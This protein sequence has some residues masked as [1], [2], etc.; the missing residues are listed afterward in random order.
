LIFFLVDGEVIC[1]YFV[2]EEE[3][4]QITVDMDYQEEEM[5]EE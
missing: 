5:T 2:K 1:S 3:R 4:Q